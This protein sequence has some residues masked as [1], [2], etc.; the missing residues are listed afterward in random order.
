MFVR[1]KI[2]ITIVP[3][4]LMN[5]LLCSCAVDKATPEEAG[6]R[7]VFSDDFNRKELGKDW[8]IVNGKWIVNNGYLR[9]GGTLMCTRNFFIGKEPVA[10]R[11]EFEAASDVQPILSFKNRPKFKVVVSDID[12]FMNAL[13]LSSGQSPLSSGYFFQFG[14]YNNEKNQIRK[15]GI[16]IA[17]D[18]KLDNLIVNDQRHKVVVEND[19][20]ALRLLVDGK[21]ILK[22]QDKHPILDPQHN[23]LGFYF[24]TA[25]KLFKVRVYAK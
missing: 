3:L 5:L 12:A 16:S 18:K 6:W 20:G 7:L 13:P 8:K 2:S 10:V 25:A 14:G 1:T 15:K 21:L 11:L 19:R 24:F 17:V 4:I 23:R 9:G 22:Y